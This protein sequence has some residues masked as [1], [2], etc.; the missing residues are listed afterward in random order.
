[1]LDAQQKVAEAEAYLEVLKMQGGSGE[2]SIW[3]RTSG[4]RVF[5]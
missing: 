3:V 4:A 2:G 1:V 5:V